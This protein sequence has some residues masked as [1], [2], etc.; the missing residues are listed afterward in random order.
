M[1]WP[2]SKVACN[3]VTGDRLVSKS[4]ETYRDNYENV[5]KYSTFVLNK[6]LKAQFPDLYWSDWRVCGVIDEMLQY[7]ET[8]DVE[9]SLKVLI[10]R[11]DG[12]IM[13]VDMKLD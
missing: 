9:N 2:V 1:I 11:G 10:S 3:E 13:K 6:K 5:F 7:A 8:Q 12:S 4:S